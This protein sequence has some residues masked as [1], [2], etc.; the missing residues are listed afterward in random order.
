MMHYLTTEQQR[1]HKEVFFFFQKHTKD[2][3][4][5]K[6]SIQVTNKTCKSHV[7]GILLVVISIF[8]CSREE[9]RNGTVGGNDSNSG[10]LAFNNT[11]C[12][13]SVNEPHKKWGCQKN[14]SVDGVRELPSSCKFSDEKLWTVNIAITS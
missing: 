3:Y 8:P 1:M 2:F 13:T 12:Y 7:D 10:R 9:N 4:D 14:P 11:C 5:D 6:L